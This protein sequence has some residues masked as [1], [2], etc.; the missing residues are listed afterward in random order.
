[1]GAAAPLASAHPSEAWRPRHNAPM[2]KP[3]TPPG[4]APLDQDAELFA[5]VETELHAIAER[6]LGRER[7]DHTL[8]PT[9]LMHEA[10]LRLASARPAWNDR[11]HFVRATA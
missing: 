5:M 9:A 11:T 2:P 10:W 4:E 6:L 3:E 1:M 8:Q 7:K